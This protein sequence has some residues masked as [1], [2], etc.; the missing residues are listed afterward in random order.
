MICVS[1]LEADPKEALRR[2]A[3]AG[4]LADLIEIRL[5]ALK[6]PDPRVFME[7]LPFPLLFTFRPKREGGLYQ[8]PEEL[9]LAILSEALGQADYLDLEHDVPREVWREFVYRKGK[10][11]LVASYH[12][13]SETPREEHLKEQVVLLKETGA[14]W[15]KVVTYARAPEDNLRLLELLPWAQK[16][17]GFPLAAFCMGP[18]G[19]ISRLATVLLGGVMTYS[20]LEEGREAAAGQIPIRALKEMLKWLE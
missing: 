18:L 6:D 7:A 17:L 2:A 5:D 13:F 10:T 1:I 20:C 19:R 8:G 4:A 11:K 16:E 12:N 3:Q 9:R 15:G 14:D